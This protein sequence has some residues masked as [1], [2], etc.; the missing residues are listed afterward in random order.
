LSAAPA[1]I[2]RISSEVIF[3]MYGAFLSAL[4]D[5]SNYHHYVTSFFYHHRQH[6]L[7]FSFFSF[8]LVF[9]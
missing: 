1:P 6:V 5:R 2:G 8:H 7:F 9:I 4:T 3:F